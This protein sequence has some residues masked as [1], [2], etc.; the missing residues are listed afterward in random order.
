MVVRGDSED[1]SAFSNEVNVEE[2]DGTPNNIQAIFTGSGIGSGSASRESVFICRVTANGTCSGDF[3]VGASGED[4]FCR[5]YEFSDE[6]A[7][8]TIATVVENAASTW[9]GLSGTGTTIDSVELTT[10]GANRLGVHFVGVAAEQTLGNFT[11]ET[12]G[13]WT[14]AVA[15]FASATGATATLQLQTA[16]M[17]AAGTIDGGTITISSAD[18]GGVA[19][20]I[21]GTADAPYTI[22]NGTQAQL[23]NVNAAGDDVDSMSYKTSVDLTSS[24]AAALAATPGVFV[25]ADTSPQQARLI[26]KRIIRF[27]ST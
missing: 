22:I 2:L 3:T 25:T 12:G 14:E 4:I 21:I 6:V 15:E 1:W 16:E 19:L 8:T 13:D 23:V 20:A 11:G 24:E 18:W 26:L 9:V 27:A 17:V 7:G 5:M 10:N